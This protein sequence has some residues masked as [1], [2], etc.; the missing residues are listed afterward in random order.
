MFTLQV[1]L[2]IL[3]LTAL[4]LA[5]VVSERWRTEEL[6]H[7]LV[8]AGAVLAGSLDV[9]ETFPRVARLVVPRTC[10]GFAVWLV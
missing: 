4:T 1:F 6:H 8:E 2:A 3:G 7:L 10:S 9:R 5:A